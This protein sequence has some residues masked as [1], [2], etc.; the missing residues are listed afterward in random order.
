[1]RLGSTESFP[2]RVERHF[3]EAL[4]LPVS[5]RVAFLA[6][7]CGGNAKLHDAVEK[8]LQAAARVK[9]NP[10]WNDA[11][12]RNEARQS[13]EENEDAALDRYRLIERIGAGGMGVVYK[14]IRADEEFSKLVAIKVV[15][16]GAGEAGQEAVLERFRQERQILASLEHPNI[17]RLLDGG[18]TP[19]GLP[20]LAM[21][22]VEGAPIDRYMAQRKAT[23]REILDLFRTLCSA[24]SYAHQKLVVHRDL[25]PANIL[26]TAEGTPKLLDFGIAKLLDG[27]GAKTNTGAAALTPEYASP[28]Q[29]RGGAIGTATDVYSMGVVLYELLSGVRP[30]RATGSIL[31]MAHAIC[32][33]TPMPLVSR[34]G[35]RIGADLN[36]I[37]QKAL[38]KETDRR[39]VSVEQFSE[40]VRRYL[41]GYPVAARPDTRGYRAWKFACRNKLAIGLG[42]V[43]A[44][45]LLG[46]IGATAWQAH[47][48]TQRFQDVRELAD[49]YLFEF[50]DAIQ[51]LPGSTPA[52]QLVVKRGLQYLDKLAQQRGSDDSLSRDLGKAYLRVGFV[53]GAPNLPSLGDRA[54]ALVSYR[55]ALAVLEP[56]EAR[57]PQNE[58]TGN[59]LS[60]AY[61]SIA[62]LQ[63]RSGDLNGAAA[64]YRKSEVLL[65]RL[66]AAR[67]KSFEVRTRLSDLEM[68]LGSLLGNNEISNLGDTRGGLELTQKARILLEALVK[69]RPA[70]GDLR[71]SLSSVYERLGAMEQALD[72]KEKAIAWL[73]MCLPVEEQLMREEPRNVVDR[74]QSAVTNRSLALMLLRTGDLA[75]ARLR[76][77]RSAELFEQLAKEDPA[78]MEA[79]E[80]LA[81]SQFSQGYVLQKGNDFAGARRYYEASLGTYHAEMAKHTGTLPTGLR[82]AYQL[83]AELGIKTHDATLALRYATEEL[84]IDRRLLAANAHNASAQRNQGTAY[85]QIGQTHEMLATGLSGSRADR[86]R[87]W[88]EARDWHR[89]ALDVWTQL[90]KEGVLI[91]A[92]TPRLEEAARKVAHCERELSR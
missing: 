60:D 9:S 74:R 62:Q 64:S 88:R 59:L 8:L 70:Q 22:F 24:V 43:I 12:I 61:Q 46:G 26:V 49:A 77:D 91:P 84:E 38:R 55:K 76:S 5:G 63:E 51:N 4:E 33:E 71:A 21:E 15:R 13:P 90:K 73:R 58:E 28:E 37:V 81:D 80:A 19:E 29:V 18:S 27:S 69:E 68:L 53:Q 79:Q 3:H 75:E 66:L 57:A 65:N 25:K 6:E 87:E 10:A 20:F 52:R 41:E 82:T 48:A 83:L 45:T 31:E 35:R 11:A 16:P 89:R 56:L 72:H 2:D 39:Y 23:E 17:A 85:G 92:Y 86:Q 7:V 67:P 42:A 36:N 44:V 47:L 40:D 54:G 78:N 34:A 50:H 14:A 30:Y 32:T 1:M